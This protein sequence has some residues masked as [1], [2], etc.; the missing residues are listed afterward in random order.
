MPQNL[1]TSLLSFQTLVWPLLFPSSLFEA[2]SKSAQTLPML[3]AFAIF[4]S[5]ETFMPQGL[6]AISTSFQTLI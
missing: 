5:K 1:D 2:F 4:L 3:L 6:A